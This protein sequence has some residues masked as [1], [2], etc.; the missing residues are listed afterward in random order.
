[1]SFE[2]QDTVVPKDGEFLQW[3]GI[4]S[5]A[6]LFGFWRLAGVLAFAPSPLHLGKSISVLSSG[7]D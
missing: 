6:C 5:E 1:M 3:C 4:C 2:L 7:W